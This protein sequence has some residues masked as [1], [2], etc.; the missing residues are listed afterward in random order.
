MQRI[1]V[2]SKICTECGFSKM[3]TTDTLYAEAIDIID[4]GILFPCH[5]Y[6]RAHTGDESHGTET[7]DEVRVCRGYVAYMKLYAPKYIIAPAHWQHLIAEITYDDLKLIWRPDDLI[8][9]HK[10]LREGIYLNNP[11]GS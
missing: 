1:T 3:G 9:N 7:L 6:L 8:A 5:M 4:R 11:L 2:C 10:G